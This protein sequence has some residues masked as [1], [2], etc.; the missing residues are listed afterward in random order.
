MHSLGW[1][2]NRTLNIVW[3]KRD[4]RLE[5]N[6]ILFKAQYEKNVLLLYIL[7]PEMWKQDDMSHRHFLFLKEALFDL[8]KK[9]VLFN[10][11]LCIKVGDAIEVFNNLNE[12]YKIKKIISHQETW[13]GWTYKRDISIKK[14]VKRQN[15]NWIEYP[16]NGV[17]RAL[18]N[19]DG[20]SRN[21]NSLMSE[22]VY[23]FPSNLKTISLTSDL[24]KIDLIE[25]KFVNKLPMK[26]K[27][28]RKSAINLLNN[29]LYINGE[30]YQKEMSSPLTAENC[31]S[32]LSAYIAFGL[33]SIREIFQFSEKRKKELEMLNNK[34]WKASINSFL[35]RLRWHCHFIQKLED[36]P[37]IQ[38][39]CFHPSYNELRRNEFNINFF[40]A[41]KSGMT[42]FPMIDASMRFLV[43]NGWINFRMRAM[44]VSFASYHLWLDW[45]KTSVFL[46]NIFTDYEPGIHYSQMQMQSGTTGINSIRI[47]NPIKQSIDH[48]PDGIFIK[49]WVP[50]LSEVPKQFIHTPWKYNLKNIKY[51]QPIVDEKIA[52]IE[53][54][55]KIFSV[56]KHESHSNYSKLVFKKHGS[57]KKTSN[58]DKK[59]RNTFQKEFNL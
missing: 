55:K 21:W 13:N 43:N 23:K 36:E 51:P 24:K 25:K 2:G 42:G 6:I 28:N 16:Q 52:R 47:Y 19:R 17:I 34:N 57:R 32:K 20:W 40:E 48:D 27:A 3:F 14:Y 41:W 44:L 30:N 31:C 35:K 15:I 4:L 56:R 53:A 58:R 45:R 37:N 33:I 10:I 39:E 11:D 18:K 50:E 9:L 12:K 59:F 38:F 26:L 8:K 22:P 49:K 1:E 54:S 7:E 29:F 46:A 5:D